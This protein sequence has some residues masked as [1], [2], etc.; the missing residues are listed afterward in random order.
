MP[1][2]AVTVTQTQTNLTRDVV[3]SDTGS[4]NVPNLLP[5]PESS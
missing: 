2:A 1:G 5:A 3:T 4:Y